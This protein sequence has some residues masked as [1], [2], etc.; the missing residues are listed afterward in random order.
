MHTFDEGEL[1]QA[2]DSLQS[3][4]IL[5][6][7]RRATLLKKKHSFTETQ[8]QSKDMPL[9]ILLRFNV[10]AMSE[11]VYS[12]MLN[13]QRRQLHAQVANGLTQLQA[14]QITETSEALDVIR[15][16]ANKV[17]V[18]PVKLAQHWVSAGNSFQAAKVLIQERDTSLHS[19]DIYAP[20]QLCEATVLILDLGGSKSA[21]PS[22]PGRTFVVP[23]GVHLSNPFPYPEVPIISDY[24]LLKI[25]ILSCS[26]LAQGYFALVWIRGDEMKDS[27]FQLQL[28]KKWH[29]KAC[30]LGRQLRSTD[31]HLL[32]TSYS[33]KRAPFSVSL[34]SQ[35]CAFMAIFILGLVLCN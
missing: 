28:A 2:L 7:V 24:E 32:F 27:A 25:C 9:F 21:E 33:G 5:V 23:G 30:D 29:R 31:A 16:G 1:A 35:T 3:H 20:V 14:E 4:H 17:K 26:K 15:E 19:G 6:T 34:S 8:R 22:T 18:I 11:V 13:H 10:A 12:N